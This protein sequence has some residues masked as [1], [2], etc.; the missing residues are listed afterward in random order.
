MR[1]EYVYVAWGN[2]EYT[3]AR[4]FRTLRAARRFARRASRCHSGTYLITAGRRAWYY[5]RGQ[6]LTHSVRPLPRCWED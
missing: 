3:W 1:H 4:A 2:A 6:R 5:N